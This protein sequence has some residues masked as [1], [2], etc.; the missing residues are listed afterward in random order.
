MTRAFVLSGGASLGASQA[1]MAQLL[2]EEGIHP[3]LIVGSS[4]GAVNGAW[5]AGGCSPG[6]L[7]DLWRTLR[8]QDLFPTR[9]PLGFRAFLG[10]SS[11]Y[12][13]DSGLRHLLERHV[14][15]AR[16]EDASI[17]FAVVTTEVPSGA[18]IVLQRGPSV[19]AVLAS[20]ALPAVFPP[21]TIDGRV[22]ID[23]GVVDNT[24]ITTAIEL[25][26]TE[27]WVLSTGSSC[28]LSEPPTSAF[29]MHSVGLMVQRRLA[30]EVAI[31][32]Y[33]VPVHLIPPPCP[34]DISPVDFS[35]SAELIDRAVAATRQWLA[36]GQP[37]SMH[38]L[39]P[40]V[41]S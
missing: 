38:L 30:L 8:R 19:D 39:A 9:L 34:I 37:D 29:A 27:V 31:R 12:V 10:R 2:L 16:L 11:H 23:G 5:L 24:P 4:V 6:G 14:T 20:A 36:D 32:D 3:E 13:S 1:G 21:V 18:E 28:A 25:G 15:F 41:H 40:H 22:L 17:P 35:Y 7:C 33:D 26:A